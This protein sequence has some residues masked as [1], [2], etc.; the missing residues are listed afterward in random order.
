M[1]SQDSK[2]SRQNSYLLFSNLENNLQRHFT[3]AKKG[4]VFH[5]HLAFFVE[6]PIFHYGLT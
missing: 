6:L 3:I 1:I 5:L 4:Q 2:V